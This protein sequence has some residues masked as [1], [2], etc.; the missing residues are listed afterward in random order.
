MTDAEPS[1]SELLTVRNLTKHYRVG[2]NIFGRGAKTVRA[3][4]DVSFTI[5]RGETLG[6]VGES[7]CG[8]STLGRS[9]LRLVPI[10]GGRIEFEGTDT[11]K[12]K[13]EELRQMRKHMQAVFQNPLG[14]LDPRMTVGATVGEPL[15]QFG[16]PRRDVRQRVEQLF[17]MVGLDHAK[18]DAY[19]RHLSGGQRQRVG[20]ARAIGLDPR[21]IVADEAVSALDV[22]VQAQIINLLVRLQRELELS[23]LFISH[24]LAVVRHISHRVGVMYLGR[25][26][27]IADSETLFATPAHPYTRA[28]LDSAQTPDPS[29]RRE[30]IMLSGD[31]PSPTNV[32]S[33]CRF[34]TRC[35]LAQQICAEIEPPLREIRPAQRAACHFPLTDITSANKPQETEPR[36]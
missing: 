12:L 26:V 33:G 11:A 16:L 7:G 30:Q 23:Y 22:S 9:L 17:D 18:I 34:R 2:G 10:E 19:P 27:E 1:R 20:I 15:T 29:Q 8:K 32:P 21:L 14:S 6:L 3:V 4:D 5:G 35:P 24:D 36:A 25:I 28:L 31:L 13:G